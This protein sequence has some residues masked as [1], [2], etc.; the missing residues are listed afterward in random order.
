MKRIAV[1]GGGI[2]GLAAAHRLREVAGDG[3]E[4]LLLEGRD[5]VGGSIGTTLQDGLVLETGPDSILTEKPW[6]V[7]LAERLGL[8]DRLVGTQDGN[9]RSF[10]V[11]GRKL[12]PTPDGFYLLAPAQMWPLVTTRIF[13]PFGKLRMG[14]DLILPRRKSEEDESVGSFVVRRLGREAL[15]RMAQP[16]IG[17]IY[18][19]D[20]M[21]LSLQATFPKFLEMERKYGSVIRALWAGIRQ[22]KSAKASGARYGLFVTFDDGLQVLVDALVDRLPPDSVR[23]GWE[24]ERVEP[25]GSRWKLVTSKGEELVDGVISALPAYRSSDLVRGFDRDLAA[26]LKLIPY[27]ASATVSLAYPESDVPHAMDGFGFVVPDV[28]GLSILGCTF[29]HRKYPKRAPEG[30]ALLRSFH[31]SRT[32]MQSPEELLASTRKDLELLLGVRAEP[33]VVHTARW[34]GSMPHYP[35]GHAKLVAGIEEQLATHANLALA[36]NAYHGL[37]LPDCIHNGE[38]AADALLNSLAIVN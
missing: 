3:A 11:R 20:P 13:S 6:A 18:G 26:R 5:R 31:G 10:V 14:M 22:R 15:D 16:M 29:C 30:M 24:V 19:A 8:S 36:G 38:G 32:A 37:G 27:G 21:E 9:R 23:T 28:E 1:I 25:A 17:G 35:V 4:L 2:T 12:H 33:Q 34:P 7:D